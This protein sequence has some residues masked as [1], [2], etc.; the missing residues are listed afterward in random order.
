MKKSLL[1]TTVV[2]ASLALAACG[3]SSSNSNSNNDE[4]SENSYEFQ[5]E[6]VNLTNAQPLSPPALVIHDDQ[7]QMFDE[8]VSA[9]TA[10]ESMA[11]GGSNS[12]L[13]DEAEQNDDVVAVHGADSPIGPGA[14]ASYTISFQANSLTGSELT[15]AT[16]LV[17]TNDAFTGQKDIDISNIAVNETIRLNG[18]VWDAGTEANSETAATI[19]GPVASGEGF[20][21]E[22]DDLN[23]VVFHTGVVTADDGLSTSVLNQSHRFDQPASQIRITRIR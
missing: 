11:E 17:N 6:V 9:T 2:A 16:M 3:G 23:V 8:G 22:R 7:Y 10:I 14:S 13:V 19:P 1:T 18:P 12:E 15:V 20:N 4:S 5:V 21:E